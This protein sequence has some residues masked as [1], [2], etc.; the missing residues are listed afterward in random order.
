M[1]V[2]WKLGFLRA[3]VIFSVAVASVVIA[4]S[5]S[6]IAEEFRLA[7]DSEEYAKSSILLLPLDCRQA[8]GKDD[9]DYKK[10]QDG[11]WIGYRSDP[12]LRLCWYKEPK[13]RTLYPEYKDVE[14]KQLSKSLYTKAGRPTR[15]FHPWREVG[16]LLAI[17]VGICGGVFLIGASIYWVLAGFAKGPVTK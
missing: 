9:E 11:P 1:A 2:N 6:R 3:W 4:G 5:Y 17:I 10:E 7:S 16:E 15:E 13:L 12:Q 14:A 8:R